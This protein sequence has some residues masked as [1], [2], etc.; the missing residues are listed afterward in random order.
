MLKRLLARFPGTTQPEWSRMPD[1]ANLAPLLLA[2]GWAEASEGDRS[3]LAK[4]ANQPYSEVLAVAERWLNTSDSPV[5]RVL[6]RW[7]LV[8]R[9]DSWHL[10][11][12]SVGADHLRRIEEVALEVLG[13]DDPAYEL[14]PDKR[15]MASLHKKVLT[16]S[17]TLRT[18]LAETLALLAAKPERVL[19]AVNLPGRV[20]Y[21]VRTLLKGKNWRRWASLSHQLP[22]LAEAAPEAFLEAADHDLG[23]KEP[24]LV[25]LFEQEGQAFLSSSPHPGL[26]WALE[27]LAWEPTYLR[28]VS[29]ILARLAELDPAELDPKGRLGNRPMRSLEEIFVPWHPQTT[30]TVEERVKVL[31]ILAGRE[32]NVG[33]RLLVSLLPD[34][35]LT[36]SP[37]HRPSWRDWTL[38]WSEGVTDAEYWHQTAA[39]A[40]LL[41]ERMGSDLSRWKQLI[42]EFDNLPEPVQK[43]FLDR[44]GACE[45][46]NLDAS[47]R[48]EITEALREKVNWH[49]QYTE[50][51][52]SLSPEILDE[53]EKLQR[54]FEPEDAVARNAWLFSPR[55]YELIDRRNID[56]AEEQRQVSE[57]HRKEIHNV[58]AESG[59]NGVLALAEAAEDPAA[60]GL[61]LGKDGPAANE[62]EV[63]PGLLACGNEK[64]SNF[65]EGYAWARIRAAGLDWLAQSKNAGWP[66]KIIGRFCVRLEF[67]RRTWE[68][69]ARMGADVEQYYW[70]HVHGFCHGTG[71]D[72]VAFAASMLLSHQRPFQ[73]C[74]VLAMALF[75][76]CALQPEL[77]MDA[78]QAGLPIP[79]ASEARYAIHQLFM[80]LQNGMKGEDTRIDPNR[81]ASLEWGYLGLLD[82]RP[83]SPKTLHAMLRNHP[84]F[85][86]Q[87]LGLVF[88]SKHE[89]KEAAREL[90]SEERARGHN[91]YQLLMQWREVPGSRDD[92]TVDEESLLSWIRKAR[93]LAAEQGRLEVCDSRIGEVF[94]HSRQTEPDGSWPCIP[95][96]D[97]IEEI[98]TEELLRG[99][100]IGIF[101]SR[102][103]H[104]RL[105]TEGGK[106]EWALRRD[107]MATRKRAKSSGIRLRQPCGRWLSVMRRMPAV[108]TPRPNSTSENDAIPGVTDDPVI[109]LLLSGE[110]ASST[111]PRRSAWIRRCPKS[112]NCW[113]VL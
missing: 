27:G 11:A 12:P 107:T 44:I 4:L 24:A 60:V 110:G 19:G 33:W 23:T 87:L 34:Q 20:D 65:A 63:L 74:E 31:K 99:F 84:E 82:D 42:G 35:R 32:R 57:L 26:L 54:R 104:G 89:P 15:W 43:E 70:R 22:V 75:Q 72:S 41:V 13:E 105:P 25:K 77:L 78:L 40:H 67:E 14:P 47:V 8:S 29:E 108:R 1:A 39:C 52:W 91:A 21:I 53:L 50:A 5:M 36:S 38:G 64:L 79:G 55:V 92:G 80:E 113:P 109:R 49:R 85:F 83:A 48:R 3:V 10:L 17:Q 101:N 51:N 62:P 97:V 61:A 106:Q 73:A 45:P 95:I 16:H 30:G 28:K 2:G 69:A 6:S 66:T 7:S 98:P 68:F 58:V 9:D 37:T 96:R 94:G 81:L 111:K 86:V 88:R 56:V 102:G 18:G 76:K 93:E 46:N 90:S 112:L 100:Q 71:E 59:F 103:M